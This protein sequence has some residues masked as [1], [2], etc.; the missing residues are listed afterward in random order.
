[1]YHMYGD[2]LLGLPRIIVTS[3]HVSTPTP[4]IVINVHLKNLPVKAPPNILMTPHL[5]PQ[6]RLTLRIIL[7]LQKRRINLPLFLRLLTT[8][9]TTTAAQQTNLQ[10]LVPQPPHRLI[11]RQIPPHPLEKRHAKPLCRPRLHYDSRLPRLVSDIQLRRKLHLFPSIS[12]PSRRL[13]A[14]TAISQKV[15]RIAQRNFIFG[16]L[17]QTEQLRDHVDEVCDDVFR[18]A[19]VGYVEKSDGDKGIVEFPE[20]GGFCRGGVGEGEPP[21]PTERI[22]AGH[23]DFYLPEWRREES[24]AMHFTARHWLRGQSPA[25]PKVISESFNSTLAEHSIEA[26]LSR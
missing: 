12:Y 4:S 20:E 9:T 11:F 21:Q 24:S 8:T 14:Y 13:R 26:K 25:M 5:R 17:W 19:V 1:M 16:R 6:L 2:P 3:F 15:G 18:D 10:K 22:V 23:N 7:P